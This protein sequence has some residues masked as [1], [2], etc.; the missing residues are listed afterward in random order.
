MNTR[1]GAY[2]EKM[3]T[4][5]VVVLGAG[6]AGESVA[7]NLAAAG[8]S[9]ALIEKL[10]VGG[11]CAY[12][13]CMPSKAML[14]SAQVRTLAKNLVALGATV[15]SPELGDEFKAF[16][17]AAL[18]RDEIA[19]HR[20][21]HS[22]KSGVLEAGIELFLG[23]GRI[24][25]E[26]NLSVNG[27]ELVWKELVIAT[28]S[29]ATIPDISGLAEI[30]YWRSDQ[31]L[32]AP[33]APTSVAIIGGGP[34][35][36][37]L[38]QIFARFGSKTTII[39]RSG[40]LAGKEDP[41][42]AARLAA[43]LQRD[44]ATILLNV[45]VIK[46]ELSREK[47]SLLTLS[48][49]KTI[50]VAQVIIAAGRH[51]QTSGINLALLGIKVGEKGEILI[52]DE[53]RVVGEQR[54][55]AAGDVTAIAPFTHTSNYQAKIITENI[56]GGN[57]KANYSAI[58]RAIYTDP[59]VASV[60]DLS[61]PETDSKIVRVKFELS[62]LSRNETDGEAGGL[63]IL[64]ADLARG[65][66]LGAAAIGAHADEWMSEAS[67]AIR[68]EVPLEILEDVVHAFPTFSQAFETP[69]RELLQLKRAH[70]DLAEKNKD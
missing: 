66:L 27:E 42:I 24:T 23:E 22:A 63:L 32:S 6:S 13:S 15:D 35:A 14:R 69:I 68:A 30:K 48:N 67:L 29:T 26:Q 16:E 34:A 40:Q 52:D 46:A 25:E 37:E 33:S 47:S 62:D 21:D 70:D 31:A 38:A 64:V 17:S 65:V 7:K 36:C 4:F 18:R 57:R 10:R 58:P 3:K 61:I 8:K 28:G 9:V 19:D 49:G 60:G 5:D 11:E 12:V 43:N 2:G 39:E 45:E 53:C 59:P 44:G 1:L 55:W 41:D 56:L 51:P 54:I 50:E 20:D